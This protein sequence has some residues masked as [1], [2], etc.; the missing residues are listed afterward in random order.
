MSEMHALAQ[1]LA[2]LISK[3]DVFDAGARIISQAGSPEP[4]AAILAEIEDTIL[5]R[6]LEFTSGSTTANLIASGRRLRGIHAMTSNP[7]DDVIG[8]TIS[9]E[10]PDLVQKTYA[11]L[12]AAFGDAERLTVRSLA[13]PE[14]G[15]GGE[16]GIS[17]HGLADLWQIQSQE[18]PKPPMERFLTANAQIIASFMHVSNDEI[19]AK[20][21][22]F[23][24][25]Q[26]IWNTQVSD[27]R[28]QHKK[29]LNG[30]DGPKLIF[31]DGALEDG[32][33]AALALV[34]DDIALLAYQTDQF[35][36]L[37]ASWRRIFN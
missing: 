6:N 22:D 16:R 17:A 11:L 4:I 21:G 33:S 31:L 10:E 26:G 24:T 9:R 18:E 8:Q 19:A 12:S 36:A 13:P 15:K 37:H 35:G 5:E 32:T 14:F 23:E 29:A 27:F 1:K 30:D 34:D 2:A 3:D 25:L 28:K 7:D 20:S